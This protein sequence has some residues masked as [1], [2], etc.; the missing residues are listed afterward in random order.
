MIPGLVSIV[1]AGPGAPDLLTVRALR[2][3]R[4]ADV[5]FHD[6]LVPRAIVRLA[7]LARHYPVSR[8]PGAVRS[9][10]GAVVELMVEAARRGDRVVRLRAGDPFVLGRGAEEALGLVE[11]GVPFQIV[12]GL[13]TASAGPTLAGIPL[14]H[15]GVTSNVVIVSGHA[16]EAYEPL[17]S[18][19]P[20]HG[21]TVVVLMGMTERAHIAELL[22]TCGWRLDT[23][24]AI[25]TNAS[26]RGE[27][28]WHDTLIALSTHS[29]DVV[30]PEPG[31]LIIGDVVRVGAV[32]AAAMHAAPRHQQGPAEECLSVVLDGKETSWQQ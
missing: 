19:L 23:P 1:G 18:A 27:R 12:P 22:L 7:R 21:A 31:V 10:P 17:L 26:R 32:I 9:A 25:V 16:P 2:C 5:V 20:S 15:R 24:A 13:T 30:H 3:L 28:I 8:R 4:Q 29:R 14:T 6:G 11:A